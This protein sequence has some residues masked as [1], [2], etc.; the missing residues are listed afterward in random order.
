MQL[1]KENRNSAE[2]LNLTAQSSVA[3]ETTANYI[4]HRSLHSAKHYMSACV[5]KVELWLQTH[6]VQSFASEAFSKENFLSAEL[7]SKLTSEQRAAIDCI[8]LVRS[9]KFVGL[10]ASSM[11]YLIQELRKLRGSAQNTTHLVGAKN[12]DLFSRTYT[13]KE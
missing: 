8:M 7:L 13:V 10:A 2:L 4:M 12:L 1:V 9:D 5:V 6:V 3:V 11:S